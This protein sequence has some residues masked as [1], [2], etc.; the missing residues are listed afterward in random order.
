MDEEKLIRKGGVYSVAAGSE[1]VRPLVLEAEGARQGAPGAEG[2][3]LVALGGGGATHGLDPALDDFIFDCAPCPRPRVGYLGWARP[4][5]PERLERLR[6]RLQACGASVEPLAAGAKADEARAWTGRVDLVYVGGGDTALLLDSLQRLPAGRVLVQAARRGLLLAGVSAGA[7]VW[8]E[9]AL[10]DAGG[11]G[12]RRLDGLGLLPGSFCPHHDSEP[13]R[14]PAFAAAVANGTLPAGL[15][16]DDGVAALVT[17]Q[18][19]GPVCSAR[20]GADARWVAPAP[21]GVRVTLLTA[22]RER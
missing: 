8:F 2:A 10:S 15:A 7:S 14:A 3:R 4:D 1:G 5:R 21:G 20:P 17:P 22:A 18:G 6:A 13:A 11:Q 9:C 19:P 12:L 16:L